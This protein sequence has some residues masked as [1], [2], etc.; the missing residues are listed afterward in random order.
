ML[1]SYLSPRGAKIIGTLEVIQAVALIDGIHDKA[2]PTTP[3]KLGVVVGEPEWSGETQVDWD[4][5]KTVTRNGSRV[6]VDAD[7][8]EWAFSDLIE[9]EVVNDA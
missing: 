9:D 2:E 8:Q 4:S 6:Y 1:R 3:E 7:Y 5:Q